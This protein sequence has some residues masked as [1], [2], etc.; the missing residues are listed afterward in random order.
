[1]TSRFLFL[2]ALAASAAPAAFAQT[3]AMMPEGSHDTYIGAL[4]TIGPRTEGS[5]QQVMLVVPNFSVNW[6]NGVFLEGLR[7]GVDLSNDPTLH[8]GPTLGLGRRAP[9]ADV[10]GSSASWS[11]DPGVYVR[12]ALA[13]NLQLSSSLDYGGGHDGRGLVMRLGASFRMPLTSHQALQVYTG[14]NLADHAYMQSYFSTRNY[15][16]AAGLKNVYLGAN[17][18][19]QLSNKFRMFSGVSLTRLA[20][21]PGLSPIV[22]ERNGA[23]VSVGV[24]YHY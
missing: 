18:N 24:S 2:L 3:A 5:K 17:W 15:D 22:E 6:S 7:A 12:Y 20:D 21:K 1:M 10:P 19:I 16:A 13:H 8:Y 23:R 11:V 9:R 4:A 14:A